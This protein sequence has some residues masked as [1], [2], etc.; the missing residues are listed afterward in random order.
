M[1]T[2]Q[3]R[4]KKY[5]PAKCFLVSFLGRSFLRENFYFQNDKKENAKRGNKI[6]VHHNGLGVD[7]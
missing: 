4:A 6:F 3:Y 5:A 7:I 2:L 1:S